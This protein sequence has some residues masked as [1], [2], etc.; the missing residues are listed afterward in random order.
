MKKQFILT[1]IFLSLTI[2]QPNSQETLEE[3]QVLSSSKLINN[4]LSGGTTH[5]ITKNDIQNYPGE[6]LPQI[7]SRLPGIEFKDLY[8]SGFGAYQSIDMRGFADTAKSNTLILLNGQKLS[9]IDLS[10]VDFLN[11][12]TDSVQE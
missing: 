7:I 12:P 9:N 2:N 6:T 5:I 10:F 11:I 3:I 8:G 4:K 1:L